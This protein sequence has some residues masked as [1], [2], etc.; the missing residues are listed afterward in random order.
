VKDQSRE[1]EQLYSTLQE[2]EKKAKADMIII[3]RDKEA[4]IAIFDA[5]VCHF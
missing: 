4:E 3:S 2:A 5:E 1:I